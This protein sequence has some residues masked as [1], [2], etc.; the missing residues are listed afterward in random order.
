[1]IY[2]SLESSVVPLCQEA[3]KPVMLQYIEVEADTP[4][5]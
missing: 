3:G 4:A 2:K 5:E 1:M